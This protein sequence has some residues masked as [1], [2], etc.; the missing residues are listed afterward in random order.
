MYKQAKELS[1]RLIRYVGT[2]ET[3]KK[4]FSEIEDSED[5]AVIIASLAREASQ[6]AIEEAHAQNVST[7]YL[8]GEDIMRVHPNGS[9]DKVGT[10]KNNRRKIKIGTKISLSKSKKA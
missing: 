9:M 5:G 3:H 1:L 8:I 6:K 10:V 2:M 7:T 4:D